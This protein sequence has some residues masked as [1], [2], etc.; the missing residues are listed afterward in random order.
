METIETKPAYGGKLVVLA[1]IK[2]KQ[3]AQN[4][5]DISCFDCNYSNKLISE[6]N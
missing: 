6:G 5:K 1:E 3:Q 4:R 2:E